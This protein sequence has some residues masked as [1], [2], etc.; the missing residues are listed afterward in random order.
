MKH[1]LLAVISLLGMTCV[2]QT[3]QEMLS[4]A[5]NAL[6]Q[7]GNVSAHYAVKGS[8]GKTSGNVGRREMLVR[9]QDNV[10]LF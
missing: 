4:R 7:S 1:I 6:K 8:Q 2:A 5:L 10:D 9:W 3:P